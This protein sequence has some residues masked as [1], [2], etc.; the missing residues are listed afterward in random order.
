MP[1]LVHRV[2]SYMLHRPTGQARVR[3]GGRDFY[4]GPHGSPESRQEYD[5]V[6]AEWLSARRQ[7]PTPARQWG[8]RARVLDHGVG[9]DRGLPAARANV[10]CQGRAAHRWSP[11]QLRHTAGT[12]IRQQ[13]GIEVVKAVLSHSEL[14]TSEI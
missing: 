8:R 3:L 2:P 14:A 11:N 10:L 5:R 12:K 7:P 9:A 6:V 1:R 4:L 13:F